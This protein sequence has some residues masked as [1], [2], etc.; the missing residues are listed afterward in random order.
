MGARRCQWRSSREM[1]RS[2][3]PSAGTVNE[4]G[5]N[6]PNVGW[7]LNC[8]FEIMDYQVLPGD[9]SLI[10]D[11]GNLQKLAKLDLLAGEFHIFELESGKVG[12]FNT[13]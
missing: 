11:I 5:P 3:G 7:R 10:W 1:L 9:D 2:H 8:P 12:G 6:E 13:R 4:G